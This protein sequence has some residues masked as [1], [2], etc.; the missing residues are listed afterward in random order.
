MTNRILETLSVC[1]LA[2]LLGA[3]NA[4]HG[5]GFYSPSIGT[6]GS[7]GTAGVANPTNTRGADAAWTNPVGMTGID[8]QHVLSGFQIIVP[9]LKFKAKG[10][11]NLSVLPRFQG[12]VQG[13][14]GGNA[15]EVAPIPS[16]F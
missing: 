14:N 11:E 5:A 3:A 6:P 7:L 10:V 12:P 9:S 16:F 2:A 8:E 15:A 1:S 4:V 13:N